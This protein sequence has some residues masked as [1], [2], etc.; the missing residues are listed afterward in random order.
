MSIVKDGPET[1]IRVQVGDETVTMTP[2]AGFGLSNGTPKV[3]SATA[4]E[5]T[6]CEA[7]IAKSSAA[8]ASSAM[9]TI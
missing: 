3:S 1:P 2:G 4:M 8:T 7:G 6:K 5:Q 9:R